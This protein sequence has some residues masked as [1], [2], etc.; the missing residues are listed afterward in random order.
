MSATA[1]E[2]SRAAAARICPKCDQSRGFVPDQ[3]AWRC[4]HCGVA[5]N[6]AE[7]VAR[8]AASR[9]A[10]Q[11]RAADAEVVRGWAADRSLWVLI[12]VNLAVVAL[13]LVQHWSLPDLMLIY[14]CQSVII[15]VSQAIRMASLREFSTDNL[16]MN[17]Q[18]VDPTP[19]TQRSVVG[20]FL[21]HYGFFHV[22]YLV[23]IFADAQPAVDW[24]L[25]LAAGAFAFHHFHSLAY[26]IEVDRRG[27]PNIGTLMFTPYL[28][29]IPMHLTIIFGGAIGI[30]SSGALLLFGLLK[31]GAD[32]GMHLV[33]HATYQG[34]ADPQRG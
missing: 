26:N 1:A 7:A 13:A 25:V 24:T 18:D 21:L 19:A 14:W 22:G 12:V 33:E 10:P 4:P 23:F 31:L 16:Q 17:E 9:L 30:Q 27:C 2:R 28:R 32:V 3:P 20:F 11:P 34:G 15:G 6:K 5:Y 29:I 8:A